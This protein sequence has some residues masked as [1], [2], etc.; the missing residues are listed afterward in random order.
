MRTDL[1]D[2]RFVQR[3]KDGD[4]S[5]GSSDSFIAALRHLTTLSNAAFASGLFKTIKAQMPTG[6]PKQ[7]QGE[8]GSITMTAA[9]MLSPKFL[10]LIIRTAPKMTNRLIESGINTNTVPTPPEKS[11]MKRSICGFPV[12]CGC[13]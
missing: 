7:Q 5:G 2:S 11:S 9:A 3:G 4:N 6:N 1:L 12:D 13:A 8:H 10:R